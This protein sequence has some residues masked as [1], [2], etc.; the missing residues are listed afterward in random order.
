MVHD[1]I[2]IGGS[3]A[4]LSAATY[5]ARGRRD[6]RIIDAGAPRNRF[7][8]HSHGFFSRDGSP[9]LDMVAE[10]RAQV[11][12]YPSV[13][14]TAARAVTAERRGD[15]FAVTL[16]S[17]EV[18]EGRYLVLA[19]GLR[20][21]LPEIAGLAAGWGKTVLHCPY[22]HGI[23]FAGEKLGVLRTMPM[24]GHQAM[25]IA[26]WGPTTYFLNGGE[27]PDAETLAELE[28]RGVA[29]EPGRV[30]GF[31]DETI[32]LQDGR[33][34]P[35]KALYLAPETHFNSDIAEQLG[36]AIDTGPM[37]KTVRTDDF[38]ATT[39]P[40]VFAAG[41]ITRSAHNVTWAV[42]DGVMAGTALH[43]SLVF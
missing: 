6:V 25:L 33:R 10:A 15:S 29:I 16:D 28:R 26:E 1:A 30:L 11:E 14:F 9:P 23:E 41:D 8:E 21:Q 35:L 5:I 20:D 3:F 2:V 12:A 17:G 4:G 18:V 7:A 31:E 19:Y 22:C 42:S 13:Q 40:G 38:K 34:L 36:C 24:S 27:A 32:T 39:V 37:G 43:R